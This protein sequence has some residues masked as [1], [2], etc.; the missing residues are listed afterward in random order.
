[1]INATMPF[2]P[3]PDVGTFAVAIFHYNL[4][5]PATLFILQVQV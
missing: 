3:L 1:M 2:V 5:H 4:V